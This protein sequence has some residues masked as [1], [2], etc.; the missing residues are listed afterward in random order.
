VNGRTE[1]PLPQKYPTLAKDARLMPLV[2]FYNA[3]AA[4]LARREVGRTEAEI[5]RQANP[6]GESA[7][8]D[9]V[10]D[11]QLDATKAAGAQ[12]AFMNRGGMRTDLRADKGIVTYSDVFSV[13]PFGNGLITLSLTGTEIDALLEE[14]WLHANTMLQVSTGF[15]YEWD[16]AQPAG[17]RIDFSRI[18]L[19]GRSLG[20]GTVYRVTVN[21]FL[22]QGGDGFAILKDAP[23]RMRGVMDVEALEHYIAQHTP[24][25][26][27]AGNRIVR[28]N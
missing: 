20:P 13:H 2:D 26:A 7:L 17:Q 18:R 16:A 4:P 1:N 28:R 27:P 25:E 5:T 15:T 19:N 10:A 3:Q 23:D 9:L 11:A 22:A 14:Q 12:I 21:E 6:S 24:I 8:G